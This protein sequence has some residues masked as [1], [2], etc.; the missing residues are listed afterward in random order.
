MD[1]PAPNSDET[2]R[3]L[4]EL[5]NGDRQAFDRL[6][7]MYRDEMS[8]FLE[9]RIDRRMQG[10]VDASD[11]LQDAQMDAWL[12]IDDYLDRE[13]MPFGVWLKRTVYE[14]LLMVRRR[15]VDA[16]RRAVGDEVPFPQQSSLL[17]ARKLFAGASS[18]SRQVNRKELA[19]RVHAAMAQLSEID[20]EILVMRNLEELPYAEIAGILNID[21]AAARK[22]HGRALLRLSQLLTD[23]GLTE[24]QL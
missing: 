10:R 11:V 6:C 14:R 3:L 12:R 24:S 15:H 20:R 5:R 8:R 23:G 16:A 18:P 19:E 13:P 7:A 22:R 1:G 9:R 4:N 17:L 2:L 21:A